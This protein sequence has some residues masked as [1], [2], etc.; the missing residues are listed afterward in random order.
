MSSHGAHVSIDPAA[1]A[2]RLADLFNDLSQAVDE[3][4]LSD[5][6][7]P[8]T[9]FQMSRLKN[10]AQALEDRAHFFTAD[11]IGATLQ[12][13]QQDLANIK[14]VTLQ[15]QQ[16]FKVLTNISRAIAIATSALS[17]ATAIAAGNPLNIAAAAKGL[18]ETLDAGSDSLG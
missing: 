16:Q 6:D 9:M 14:S 17:L 10:E 18:A 3:F 5:L 15:A 4:R 12:T 2:G 11:A 8:L 1:E 7:P 13:I